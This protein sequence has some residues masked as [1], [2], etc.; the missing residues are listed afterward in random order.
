M[1]PKT[2]MRLNRVMCHLKF[3]RASDKIKIGQKLYIPRHAHH[4]TVR[5][6]DSLTKIAKNYQLTVAELKK[7]NALNSQR[8]IYPGQQLTIY[9]S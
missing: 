5:S 9:L 3:I 2:N 8:Y 7:M 6:G 4:Y 1:N